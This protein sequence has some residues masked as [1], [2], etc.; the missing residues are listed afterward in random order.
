MKKPLNLGELISEEA[1]ICTRCGKRHPDKTS[2]WTFL[3]EEI[4]CDDCI[5]ALY[6][7]RVPTT[8]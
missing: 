1:F 3:K 7:K 6:L 4:L 8:T 5:E 2:T